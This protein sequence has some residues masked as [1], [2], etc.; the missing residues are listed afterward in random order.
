MKPD[1]RI[2]YAGF[3]KRENMSIG[4]IS[5]MFSCSICVGLL[6]SCHNIPYL[7]LFIYIVYAADL[8]ISALLSIPELL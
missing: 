6:S 3:S 8:K 5:M 2:K 1:S 7:R 4:F